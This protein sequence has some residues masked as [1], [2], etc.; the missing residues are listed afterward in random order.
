MR[1]FLNSDYTQIKYIKD[2][3]LQLRTSC[4]RNFGNSAKR[5]GNTYYNIVSLLN[6]H[7]SKYD[8]PKYTSI[9]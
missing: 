4:L 7:L 2:V 3:N 5:A 8:Y 6:L 1:L 9:F